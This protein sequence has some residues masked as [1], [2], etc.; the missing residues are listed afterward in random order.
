MARTTISGSMA[1]STLIEMMAVMLIIAMLASLVV[2]TV[3]GTGRG[4]L[5]ALTLQTVAL[6]RRERLAAILTGQSRRV[7]LDGNTRTIVAQAGTIAIPRDVRVDV[8]GVNELW[9]G[10]QAVVRFEPDG[11]STG[12]V[13]KFSWENVRYEVDVNW[14]NGRVAVDLP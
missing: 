6:L 10:R 3:P 14:Y 8:I 4:S 9:S 1:G 11:A 5:K 13:L 12:S 7:S 2:A